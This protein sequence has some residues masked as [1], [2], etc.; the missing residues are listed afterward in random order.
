MGEGLI[1]RVKYEPSGISETSE[2]GIRR[3]G[4]SGLLNR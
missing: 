4:I 1:G 2:T 3:A